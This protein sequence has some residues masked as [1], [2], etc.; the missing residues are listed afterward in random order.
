MGCLH[1]QQD[2]Y[3][4]NKQPLI[5]TNLE[6]YRNLEGAVYTSPVQKYNKDW[7]GIWGEGE[8][9]GQRSQLIQSVWVESRVCT[10]TLLNW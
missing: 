8:K 5:H 7:Q 6:I 2:Q 9:T 4:A 10:T 3:G 1:N